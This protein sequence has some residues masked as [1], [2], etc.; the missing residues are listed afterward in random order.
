MRPAATMPA[1]VLTREMMGGA[2]IDPDPDFAAHREVVR[3]ALEELVVLL[4]PAAG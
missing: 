3:A 2:P 1:I 4:E